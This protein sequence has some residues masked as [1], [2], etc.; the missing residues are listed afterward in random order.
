[1]E[2]DDG[3]ATEEE[4]SDSSDAGNDQVVDPVAAA[5]ATPAVRNR[6]KRTRR[7]PARYQSDDWVMHQQVATPRG[8]SHLD[9]IA[10]VLEVQRKTLLDVLRYA[11][12]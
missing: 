3:P 9:Q 5:P 7:P 11:N 6:P 12:K 4:N 8:N 10:L 1:M 2:P